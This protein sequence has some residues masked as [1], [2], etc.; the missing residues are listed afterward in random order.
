MRVS[1]AIM[2]VSAAIMKGAKGACCPSYRRSPF[3]PAGLAR[4]A[5]NPPRSLRVPLSVSLTR[6]GFAAR[7]TA[8][9]QSPRPAVWSFIRA[10]LSLYPLPGW[11][12]VGAGC[13]ACWFALGLVVGRGWL[14]G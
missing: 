3:L 1:A 8:P 10:D 5:H 4:V 11:S 14:P 6:R 2:R 9:C 13:R 12:L 7:A